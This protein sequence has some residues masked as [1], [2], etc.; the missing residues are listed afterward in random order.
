VR[1]AMTLYAAVPTLLLMLLAAAIAGDKTTQKP[2]EITL[3]GTVSCSIPP[4]PPPPP[5][6]PPDP[7]KPPT[8]QVPDT[9]DLC[10][11]RRGQVVLVDDVTKNQT[12]I[13]NPDPVKGYEGRRISTSG[14][15]NGVGN[16]FHVVSVRRI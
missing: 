10:L 11:A 14:Y 4:A 2:T 3:Y 1:K 16:S 8:P 5:A 15:M 12:T 9:V 6:A 7:T 13:E